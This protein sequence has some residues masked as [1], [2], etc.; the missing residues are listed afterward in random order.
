MELN[1]RTQQVLPV[2]ILGPWF[3]I[4]RN[5]IPWMEVNGH[6]QLLHRFPEGVVVG[7]VVLRTVLVTRAVLVLVVVDVCVRVVVTVAVT[8]TTEVEVMVTVP[9]VEEDAPESEEEVEVEVEEAGVVTVLFTLEDDTV[10][11]TELDCVTS[12]AE[13]RA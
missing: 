11:V 13:R 6:I 5:C 4:L 12:D 8:G 3:E 10:E 7:V 2:P 9:L 1:S